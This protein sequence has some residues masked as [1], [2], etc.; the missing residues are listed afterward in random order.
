MKRAKLALIAAAAVVLGMTAAPAQATP[1][2]EPSEAVE[3]YTGELGARE[4]EQLMRSGVSREDLR[5]GKGKTKDKVVVEVALGGRQAEQLRSKG[6]ELTVKRI[7]GKPASKALDARLAKGD[8][9]YKKYGGPGGIREQIVAAA[10]A[11][12]DIAKVVDIGRTHQG[13]TLT[14]IKV[15][16]G[17]RQLRDGS[18]KAML[19]MSA[20]HAREWITPEMTRRLL[21]HVLAGYAGNAEIKKLVDTTELWFIPVANPD[22]Y[23][24]TFEPGQRLWRKNLRDNDGD[25]RITG[26]DGV[27]L[28]RNFR[29][30]WGYDNEGS[31]ENPVSLTYRGP[32]AMSEPEIRAVDQLA[33]RV[34][35]TYVLNYH[36]A[37]ELLLYG[38]GWQQATPTPD[39][40]IFEALLGDDA[41]PAVPGYDPDIGA[42]LYIT[43]GDTDGHMTNVRGALAVTPEMTTC[44]VAVQSDPNDE[45]TLEDCAG[46]QGFTFPDSEKLIQAEFAKNVP[47]ALATAKSVH[48]PDD[49]V[50]VVGRSVP[51]FRI[52][53]FTE[54]YGDPQPVAVTAR[55][56]LHAKLMHF[57]INGGTAR[58][59]PVLEWKGG[60][61]YGDENDLYFAEYRSLVTGAK[62]GDKVEVWFSGVKP[63][64]GRVESEKFTYT[65]SK[66]SRARVLVL[67]NEDYTGFNP[68]YPPTV[69]APKYAAQYQKELK[70]A[71]YD[72]EVWDVDKQGVP[73]HLGVL[74]HFRGVAWYLG[75]N[76]LSMAAQDVETQTPFGPLPDLDVKSSQHYLTLSVRDYLNE[77]GK[78]MHTGETAAYYGFFGAQVGGIYYGLDGNPEA[79]CVITTQAGFFE[80]CLILADDFTQ[81]YMGVYGRTPREGPTGFT[82][83]DRPYEGLSATFGPP[84]ANP[85]NEAG[86]FQVT[87]DA[88][89]PDRFPQFRSWKAG[90]Y[91]G[92]RGPFDPVEGDWY[93]AG[94]HQDASYMRLTRTFD[95]TS[96]TAAQAP[97]LQFQMSYDME[98]GYDNVII[99]AHTAGAEDWTTLP[100][101]TGLSD[102]TVP[103]ECEAGFYL[104]MHPWL[105]HYLTGGNP[106]QPRGT[107]GTWNRI[108]GSSGGWKPVSVDL[109]AYAGKRVEISIS[110]VTDPGSG[111]IG[112]F[113]DDTKLVVGGTATQ[114]EGFETGMGAWALPGPPAGSGAGGDFTRQQ[115]DKTAAVATRDTVILGFGVEQV[116]T[117]AQRA[118]L[119][120]R[121]MRY[122]IGR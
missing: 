37:A 70:A 120:G 113:V 96:V 80:E 106:C 18:R 117:E 73:H 40:L 33:S 44:E 102:T 61:R 69:T 62:P 97:K 39:D 12:P 116:A 45:W 59:R 63:G 41:R 23:D 112:V 74:G 119:L 92:A 115:A 78:V 64:K 36:S 4:L 95:L 17:A 83:T 109:S 84:A 55:R 52:D 14:A 46:G 107:T 54:S 27:D 93:I 82:G 43:N 28:N 34:R 9:V 100:D 76:R 81:Y 58:T 30:K 66:D 50:S 103:A 85:L 101:E 47:L 57:R 42:E 75:D 8:N 2:P 108:T 122:L 38:V 60:E 110:Y 99:E 91:E 32:A 13:Q 6:V 16:K 51:D 86:N 21:M 68:D 24:H 19:Y 20:Q 72:S 3:V 15:T 56:S 10:N 114:A 111:G 89:P 79:D 87:S 11:H 35:F 90:D 29:Y 22:G 77:G 71:G 98:S 88:L 104:D 26:A 25:G 49:P 1:K 5:Y 48:D 53:P 67:A 31:S 105:T 65:L 118:A 94:P 121:A 7:G